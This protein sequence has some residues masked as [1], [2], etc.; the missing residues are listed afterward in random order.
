[1]GKVALVSICFAFV[2]CTEAPKG[3]T[4]SSNSQSNSSSPVGAN[5][6]GVPAGSSNGTAAPSA[7]A[8]KA[9]APKVAT[10]GE[11]MV[12]ACQFVVNS[13][14]LTCIEYFT[15]AQDYSKQCPNATYHFE[16]NDPQNPIKEAST[17]VSQ[18]VS[19]CPAN[20]IIRGCASY[21][22]VGGGTGRVAEVVWYYDAQ[23]KDSSCTDGSVLVN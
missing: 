8:P 1:M 5:P 2:G 15:D 22:G 13:K 4:D 12:G 18:K 23:F 6:V 16:A 17:L 9:L 20:G 14:N 10:K 21:D 19:M 11:S 7:T 3:R